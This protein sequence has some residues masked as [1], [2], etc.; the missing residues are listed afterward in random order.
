MS[1]RV[2][3]LADVMDKTRGVIATLSE[4]DFAKPTPC[5]KWT[6]EQLLGH[7]AGWAGVFAEAAE[8]GKPKSPEPVAATQASEAFGGSAD[9]MVAAFRDGAGE[10]PL[11]LTSGE[12]PGEAVLGM[13]VMEYVAHGWDLAIATG[14]QPPYTDAEAQVALDA[15]RAMLR[16]EYRGP[17]AMDTP[18]EVADDAPT[19]SKFIGFVGR[20]PA[21]AP[22][23]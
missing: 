9:R 6:V 1:D 12:L 2:D 15:G 21:W 14:Q 13:I 10:R 16:P 22:S 11:T 17:D 23:G 19:L 20:D 8:G 7:V 18:V 5:S 4:K 3:V